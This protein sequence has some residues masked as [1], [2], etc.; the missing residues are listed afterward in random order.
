VCD[1]FFPLD[2]AKVFGIPLT[3]PPPLFWVTVNLSDIAEYL[4]PPDKNED[5]NK[6]KAAMLKT[7]PVSIKDGYA[8]INTRNSNKITIYWY[9]VDPEHLYS[10]LVQVQIMVQY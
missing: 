3:I 8:Y 1:K 4:N 9:S 6:D 10:Y 7:V 2:Y 5:K